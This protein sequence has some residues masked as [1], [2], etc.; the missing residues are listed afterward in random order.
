MLLLKEKPTQISMYETPFSC[1]NDEVLTIHNI[2]VY[3][4]TTTDTEVSK[5]SQK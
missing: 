1:L 3:N 5:L 2:C 4:K